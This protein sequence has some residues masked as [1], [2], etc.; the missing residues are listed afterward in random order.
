MVKIFRK[1]IFSYLFSYLSENDQG[2][3]LNYLHK[4]II[5]EKKKKK[6]EKKK[7]KYN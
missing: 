4:L 3:R 6:E 5:E 7:K 2:S 1:F